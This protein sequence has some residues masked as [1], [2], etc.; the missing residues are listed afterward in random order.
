MFQRQQ[1]FRRLACAAC[2]LFLVSTCFADDAVKQAN[3]FFNIYESICLKHL[4][5]M[6]EA[7]EKLRPLPALPPEKAAHFL[8]GHAGTAWPVPDKHGVFVLT[9]YEKKNFCA[10]HARRIKADLVDAKFA[11]TF[12]K[13]PAPLVSKLMDDERKTHANQVA[14]RTQSYTWSAPGAKRKM[15]FTLTTSTSAHAPLQ[16][17]LS[18]ATIS[19]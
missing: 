11:T 15:L 7:R 6:D 16:G 10:V 3:S 2:G 5:N 9:I 4:G 17:M 14:T 1:L 8:A 19:E 12:S 13:A 18:A